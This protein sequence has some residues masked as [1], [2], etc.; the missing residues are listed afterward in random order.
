MQAKVRRMILEEEQ[1]A[2]ELEHQIA[3]MQGEDLCHHQPAVAL[4]QNLH[5]PHVLAFAPAAFQ[6]PNYLEERSPLAPE[7][8]A[9]SWLQNYRACTYPSVG[10][11][12]RGTLKTPN[13]QLV[14]PISI[15]LLRPDGCD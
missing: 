14:T 15:K 6:G 12:I 5:H 7:L 10:T 1:K 3:E 9:S 11:I 8:Q 2:R 4:N 13:S